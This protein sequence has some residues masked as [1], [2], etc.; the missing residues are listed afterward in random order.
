M[1]FGICYSTSDNGDHHQNQ[2]QRLFGLGDVDIAIC[3]CGLILIIPAVTNSKTKTK[4]KT[5]TEA[6]CQ[7]C[8]NRWRV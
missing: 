8:G 4:T 3:T 1:R 6:I 7:S 5:H 2:A